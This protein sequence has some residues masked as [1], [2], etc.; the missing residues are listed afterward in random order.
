VKMKCLR[1]ASKSG[2]RTLSAGA[3]MSRQ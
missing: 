1:E 2:L 3:A